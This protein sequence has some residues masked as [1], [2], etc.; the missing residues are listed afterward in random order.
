MSTFSPLQTCSA[1]GENGGKNTSTPRQ[2]PSYTLQS[3]L[4]L[5]FSGGKSLL[6]VFK[7]KFQMSR[8][9]HSH[10]NGHEHTL[11]HVQKHTGRKIHAHKEAY[12]HAHTHGQKL[13]ET[14]CLP[15]SIL[16][17][18]KISREALL[19]LCWQ[20]MQR[21]TLFFRLGDTTSKRDHKNFFILNF[22]EGSYNVL[23][24]LSLA[25]F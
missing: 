13:R 14:A 6:N 12:V 5:R 20:K 16:V 15:V 25:L 11:V 24:L 8:M 2:Q 3:F 7:T 9:L 23:T 17:S 18:F 10:K 1:L 19:Q 22:K 4:R 21:T